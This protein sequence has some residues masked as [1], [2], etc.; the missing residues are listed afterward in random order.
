M[1]MEMGHPYILVR[2]NDL[3]AQSFVISSNAYISIA[4][5]AHVTHTVGGRILS[6]MFV[7]A[8]TQCA[9]VHKC[10]CLCAYARVYLWSRVCALVWLCG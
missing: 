9:Q 1:E 3:M 6:C 2:L 10:A 4:G 8:R 5:R 7:G